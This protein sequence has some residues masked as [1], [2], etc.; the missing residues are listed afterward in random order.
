[1]N[2]FTG[3]LAFLFVT[4]V[5]LP[6]FAAGETAAAA[7]DYIGFLAIGAGLAIGIAAAGGGMGQGRAAA[8]GNARL[9]RWHPQVRALSARLPP[10][11]PQPLQMMAPLHWLW[12]RRRRPC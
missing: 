1:M 5:A 12:L 6:A 9:P 11:P 10:V 8:A 7:G 4:F 2:R 3:L